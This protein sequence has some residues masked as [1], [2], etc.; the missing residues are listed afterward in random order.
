MNTSR[1]WRDLCA[2]GAV[3]FSIL[4]FA[5]RASAAIPKKDAWYTQHYI[6]MQDFERKLYRDLSIE[7]RKNFQDLFW[8]ARTP[9]ARAKFQARLDYVIKNFWKEN[10]KQPWNTDR[11]RT[12]L[13]NGSPASIDYDQNVSFGTMLPGQVADNA[14]RSGEDVGANRGEIWIYPFDQYFIKYTFAFVQPSQWRITQ[15][16]GNRYLGELETFNKKVTFGL[17]DEAAYKQSLEGLAKNK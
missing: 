7:G 9:E 6:I 2:L 10:S 8:A 14:N 4:A 3:G 5:A 11:G 17:V 16:T 1:T 12:Y 15:T 13:L